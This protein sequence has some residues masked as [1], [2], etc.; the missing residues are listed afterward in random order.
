MKLNDWPVERLAEQC[1]KE[2]KKY[3][4]KFRSNTS[5]CYKLFKK[6]FEE[7]SE[8]ALNFIYS[9]YR[10]QVL[11]WIR[12]HPYRDMIISEDENLFFDSMSHFAV[13]IM[14]YPLKRFPAIRY[15]MAYL[16][17]CVHSVIVSIW[18]K[19]SLPTVNLDESKEG[20]HEDHLD[21]KI[22]L[23]E[24]WQRIEQLLED[25]NELLL[26]HLVFTQNLKPQQILME[27]PFKWQDANQIRVDCQRIKRKLKK[28]N[29]LRTI[30]KG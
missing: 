12:K 28:D 20:I 27:Y 9:I 19:K 25:S 29:V 23:K 10:P 17:K 24:A 6:A 11:N 26:A 14:Q 4:L 18:R 5:F 16:R 1:K 30:L 2:T 15:I 8:I 3:W 21:E 7:K 22:M 13:S